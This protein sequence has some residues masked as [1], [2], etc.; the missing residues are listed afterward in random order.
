MSR[1]LWQGSLNLG[2]FSSSYF[3]LVLLSGLR[4]SELRVQV[5]NLCASSDM[6]WAKQ[7]D[8]VL[9]PLAPG[10]RTSSTLALSHNESPRQCMHLLLGASKI[11]PPRRTDR[12]EEQGICK[13]APIAASVLFGMQRS[14]D[15][16]KAE[17]SHSRA[18]M[19]EPADT[20]T[21][22]RTKTV[23]HLRVER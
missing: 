3:T 1:A 11:L 20:A 13:A 2:K 4:I 6:S 21:A 5:I 9:A 18:V 7:W 17:L 12:Y 8:N 23:K 16:H 22:T 10:T 19:P 14:T 15:K